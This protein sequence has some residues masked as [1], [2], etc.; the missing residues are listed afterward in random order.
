MGSQF[1]RYHFVVFEVLSIDRVLAFSLGI[2]LSD[3]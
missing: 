2:V 1:G 3:F